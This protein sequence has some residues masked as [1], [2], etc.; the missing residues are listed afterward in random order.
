MLLT[1]SLFKVFYFLTPPH[2]TS[3]HVWTSLNA[4]KSTDEKGLL[5]CYIK[6]IAIVCPRNAKLS[7]KKWGWGSV[8]FPIVTETVK[9][10]YK[11][12]KK[13]LTCM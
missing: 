12:K 10:L 8:L 9:Y 7:M 6:P 3:N 1:T 5:S 11:L 4:S 2:P 13:V